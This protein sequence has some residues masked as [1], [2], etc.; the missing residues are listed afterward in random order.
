MLH[1]AKNHAKLE[2]VELTQAQIDST[3]VMTTP[4]GEL[5]GADTMMRLTQ[6]LSSIR[7]KHE[8]SERLG[9]PVYTLLTSKY[10]ASE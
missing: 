6:H 5:K 10:G 7:R 3:K 8:D 1:H 2:G 9:V 4:T